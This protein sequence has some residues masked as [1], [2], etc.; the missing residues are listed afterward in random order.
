MPSCCIRSIILT[1]L[2]LPGCKAERDRP[3]E[4]WRRET[5]SPT[6]TW[7]ATTKPS[8]VT[9][10]REAIDTVVMLSPSGKR[11]DVKPHNVVEFEKLGFKRATSEDLRPADVVLISPNYDDMV[12]V[13]A[14]KVALL[15]SEGW[16]KAGAKVVVVRPDGSLLEAD[17]EDAMTMVKGG[18][19][20]ETEAQ[21]SA[22][23]R[24]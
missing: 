6:S 24:R 12:N 22:R 8:G 14:D 15:V 18:F 5:T 17:L 13:S 11:T 3:P 9:G 19:T 21:R 2:I 7:S 4:S 23:L 10:P 1:I 16:T 20:L